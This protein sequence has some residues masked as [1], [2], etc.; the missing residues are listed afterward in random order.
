[1]VHKAQPLVAH[2]TL[3]NLDKVC[4]HCL[5]RLPTDDPMSQEGWV[6]THGG[7]DGGGSADTC[8]KARAGGMGELSRSRDRR[9]NAVAPLVRHCVQHGLT[10]SRRRQTRSRRRS[11][12]SANVAD[13]LCF[14]NFPTASPPE[15]G[16][17][18]TP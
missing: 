5:A 18:N 14:V 13:P 17:K 16:S 3:E 10:L 6:P 4:Y 8:G 2:P 15:I 9:G 12:G 1:M 7:G 11:A